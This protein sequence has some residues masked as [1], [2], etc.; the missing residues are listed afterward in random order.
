MPGLV[1][2]RVQQILHSTDGAPLQGFTVRAPILAGKQCRNISASEAVE[3]FKQVAKQP[4][5]IKIV[6]KAHVMVFTDVLSRTC[7]CVR[8]CAWRNCAREA[9]G[10]FRSG[11]RVVELVYQ[12]VYPFP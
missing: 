1:L 11:F 5:K 12:G 9:E 4:R 7:V 10:R 2:T 6:P 3:P 8:V